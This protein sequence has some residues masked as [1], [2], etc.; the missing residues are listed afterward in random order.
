MAVD[1]STHLFYEVSGSSTAPTSIP[2]ANASGWYIGG[3]P[4]DLTGLAYDGQLAELF[5]KLDT[6]V[7][8]GTIYSSFVTSGGKAKGL[9]SGCYTPFSAAPQ[10]CNRGA[11][12]A[13]R[14]GLFPA[15]TQPWADVGYALLNGLD[16]P[17][18]SEDYHHAYCQ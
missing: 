14:F 6:T 9:G 4:S 13:F 3:D 1:G 11:P 17:C 12:F 7:S 16:D 8:L 18:D 10:F 5:V 2:W 15:L